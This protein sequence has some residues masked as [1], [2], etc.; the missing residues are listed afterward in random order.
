M[1]QPAPSRIDTPDG[2]VRRICAGTTASKLLAGNP[3]VI[4][5]KPMRITWI[6]I[7]D[8]LCFCLTAEVI[9]IQVA[10]RDSTA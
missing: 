5:V 8:T 1:A 3:I 4:A 2:W 10:L 7:K 9:T 6:L